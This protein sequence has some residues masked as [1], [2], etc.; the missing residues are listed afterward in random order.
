[1]MGASLAKLGTSCA[2]DADLGGSNLHTLVGMISKNTLVD[3]I[4]KK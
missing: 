4:S 3:F 1:M 2:L